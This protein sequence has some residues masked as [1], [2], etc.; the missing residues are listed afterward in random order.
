MSGVGAHL[1]FI[2][3]HRHLREYHQERIWCIPEGYVPVAAL[4]K[5]GQE[6]IALGYMGD[7]K[8]LPENCVIEN[9]IGK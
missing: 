8:T 6:R 1:P 3:L 9:R 5:R 2:P 7:S 4:A